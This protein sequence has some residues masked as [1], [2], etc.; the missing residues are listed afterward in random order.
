[1]P[2]LSDSKQSR[3]EDSRKPADLKRTG[4]ADGIVG[5]E[6]VDCVED[7]IHHGRVEATEVALR[8]R[9]ELRPPDNLAHAWRRNSST[10]TVCPPVASSS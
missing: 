9:R 2:E 4:V 1:M 8:T 10:D 3:V 5:A 6:P 7:A